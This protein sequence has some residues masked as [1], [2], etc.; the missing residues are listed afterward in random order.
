MIFV[1]DTERN[2]VISNQTGRMYL[3][4]AQQT[5]HEPPLYPNRPGRSDWPEFIT[6]NWEVRMNMEHATE[7]LYFNKKKIQNHKVVLMPNPTG[8]PVRDMVIE[9]EPPAKLRKGERELIKN[10]NR[11][12]YR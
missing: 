4:R 12:Q 7:E 10:A 2:L 11:R 6:T 3:L 8:E 5:T 9:E 1:I